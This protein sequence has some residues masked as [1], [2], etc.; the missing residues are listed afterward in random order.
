VKT[1]NILKLS[2][3]M[4]AVFLLSSCDHTEQICDLEPE[5]TNYK[6]LQKGEELELRRN[7]GYKSGESLPFTGLEIERYNSCKIGILATYEEGTVTK[8]EEWYDDGKKKSE[9][10]F[11]MQ[12]DKIQNHGVW[13][14]W[15][16]SGQKES[17]STWADNLKQG[18]DIA[19]HENGIKAY[20][21]NYINGQKQGFES[22]WH[23]SGAMNSKVRYE[24]DKPTGVAKVWDDEGEILDEKNLN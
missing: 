23:D 2:L 8:L 15:Y 14:Y 10:R 9:T 17:Q 18:L 6:V 16:E 11:K 19:W 24:N 22:R 5:Y 13:K 3:I 12:A 7:V 21:V 1:N 4:S 20:E